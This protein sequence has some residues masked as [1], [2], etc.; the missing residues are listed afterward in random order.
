MRILQILFTLL[1]LNG[2]IAS[3]Q[4]DYNKQFFTAKQF[5]REGKYNLAMEGF[6]PLISYDQNNQFLEYASFYYALSAY[7]QGFR[8]VAKDMLVQLK[9][10]HSTWDK[11]DEVNFWLAKIHFDNKDYFQA[12]K[13][14]AAIQ[15]K[16]MQ[17]DVDA[18]KRESL[19]TITDVETLKMMHEEYPK[20]EILAVTLAKALS[21]DLT[22]PENR[23]L[24]ESLISAHHLKRDEY[25]PEAPKT[26]FKDTYTVSVLMPF[27]VST[28]DP[29]PTRKKSQ[30]ILDFYEGMKLA[31]DTL[32][33]QGI[34]ISLRA[35][36]TE[37]NVEKIKTLLA[38]E[39]LK[40]TDLLVGPF[41][42]E[43]NK[44]IQDFSLTQKINVFHPMWN[45]I[46]AG[47]NPY[48]FLFQPSVETQGKKSGEFLATYARKKNCIIY[49]GPSRRD[50]LLA[51][52]FSETASKNGLKILASE[53]I[54]RDLQ[55]KIISTLATPTEFDEYK[56]PKQFSLKK[57]SLGSIFVASD[58]PLL[59]NK[60][61][62][63]IE[64]RGDSVIVLGS[65]M[66]LEQPGVD[67]EKYQILP[68]VLAA[69]N[70]ALFDN[71]HYQAFVKKFSRVHGRVPSTYARMGYEFMLFS[72]NQLKKNG[73]YFQD[74]LTRE[75][76]I[77]GYLTQ[78]FN[79]QFSHD[80]NLVPFVRFIKGKA[81]VVGKY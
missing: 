77:P 55:G 14:L 44:P 36:D 40:S 8:A 16:K 54:T 6:K 81:T 62:G 79:Y 76:F 28:L 13:I 32:D 18:I 9:M 19:A 67:L 17:K 1:F 21:R 72:G 45:N 64:T 58:D 49:Y 7:N 34:K 74:A 51:A 75:A 52:A 30:F 48:A 66:W 80:N 78:G 12:M 4:I 22:I 69:P 35:Y 24:L 68:V 25:I 63:A 2:V 15:D 3:A 37:R 38:T 56:Y 60:V 47:V 46:D 43:E 27:M 70:F 57:D 23:T 61:L 65:E 53:R 29:A 42:P 50:S 10:Q 31:A 41:F 71:L 26:I 33:K 73:V 5:F 39:E 20:D 11:I 59:Y